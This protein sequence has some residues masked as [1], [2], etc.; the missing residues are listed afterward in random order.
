MIKDKELILFD[1]DG[2]L[3]D[4]A[5]DL[6]RSINYMLTTI[7]K[8]NFS[9]EEIDSWV[10]NGAKTL[11]SRALSGTTIIDTTL[12]A[13][14]V[15]DALKIFLD[16]YKENVC[17][18]TVAYPHV[19]SVLEKLKEDGYKMAIVTNKPFE[20]VEPI[21]S[22]LGLENYF[23]L[24]IGGDSLEKKKPEPEPLLYLCEKLGVSVDRTLMIG[25]SKNDIL[26]ATAAEIESIG[27]TYGYN[28]GE[29]IGA[30]HP[31]IVVDNFKDI[32]NY[33]GK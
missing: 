30:Y 31:N 23:E 3:I 28:Y 13:D 33:I 18:K 10:G 9:D 5:P 15:D 20:F 25:D 8:E 17:V 7:G 11:V 24:S 22:T 21:L 2:T 6:A 16:F 32:L 12:D 29:D 4:S 27:V 1:L 26:A 14:F 19:A